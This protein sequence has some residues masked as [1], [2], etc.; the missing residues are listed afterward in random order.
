[1]ATAGLQ[2][3]YMDDSQ[4]DQRE[5]HRCVNT[6]SPS[7]GRDR[8]LPAPFHNPPRDDRTCRDTQAEPVSLSQLADLGVLYWKLDPANYEKDSRLQAVRDEASYRHGLC[9]FKLLTNTLDIVQALEDSFCVLQDII[10]VTPE[11]LPGYEQQ[12]KSFFEEHLHTDEE[13]RYILEGS[14]GPDPPPPQ[15]CRRNTH[16]VLLAEVDICARVL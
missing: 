16:A 9:C 10:T 15:T 4:A 14:G 8:S 12:L 11:N 2:A 13:V 6:Q 7:L 5:P 1:M 3:W